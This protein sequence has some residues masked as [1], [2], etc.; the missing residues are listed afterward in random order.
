MIGVHEQAERGLVG[1]GRIGQLARLRDED[2]S[3]SR[4]LCVADVVGEDRQAVDIGGDGLGDRGIERPGHL[5]QGR[6]RACGRE[7]WE[8]DGIGKIGTQPGHDLC[9]RVGVGSDSLDVGQGD[10]AWCDEAELDREDGFV[11]DD[12]RLAIRQLVEGEGHGSL[13]G[14]LNRDEREVGFTGPHHAKGLMDGGRR[15]ELGGVS[16][17]EGTKRRLGEG[18]SWSEEGDAG[19]ESSPRAI[20]TASISS[21]ER[22]T[23]DEP[24]LMPLRYVRVSARPWIE[25]RMSPSP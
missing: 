5:E 7:G 8:D 22:P 18:S 13:D 15:Q 21:G 23:S 9:V 1:A 24:P 3:G 16:D 20:F 14:V 17:R 12:E 11:D 19:H 25:V 6:R 2:E 4:I 10:A